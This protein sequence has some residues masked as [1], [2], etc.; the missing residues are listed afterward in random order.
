MGDEGHLFVFFLSVKSNYKIFI[1]F[2][3]STLG[4]CGLWLGEGSILKENFVAFF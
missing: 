1:L 3:V 4:G 2:L